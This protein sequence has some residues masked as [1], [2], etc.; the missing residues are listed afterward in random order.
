MSLTPK[1]ET[2]VNEWIA[3]GNK[4]EAYRTAYDAENM[5]DESIKVEA[6]RLSDNP[7][8]AL[9]YKKITDAAQKRNEMSQDKVSK[10]YQLAYQTAQK[11]DRPADMIRAAD[12][13]STLYGLN[14]ETQSKI[15]LVTMNSLGGDAPITANPHV[16]LT[17]LS[18]HAL[19]ELKR[20]YRNSD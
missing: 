1:Q 8:V 15:K 11:L 13:L 16:D 2:F 14:E 19:D 6:S 4:S 20:A 7:N 10:M 9:T 3:T 12:G 17:M 18:D 5:S